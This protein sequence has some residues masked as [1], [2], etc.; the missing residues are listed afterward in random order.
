MTKTIE[1]P[2]M[3]LPP[4]PEIDDVTRGAFLIGAA[5]L[6]LIP[7]GCGSNGGNGGD[8]SGETRTVEH[9]LGGVVEN[10]RTYEVDALLWESTPYYGANLLPDD[11]EKHLL[12]G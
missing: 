11:I 7:A 9:A 12:N 5:G 4:L 1:R 10:G 3:A 2:E 6:L 8:A